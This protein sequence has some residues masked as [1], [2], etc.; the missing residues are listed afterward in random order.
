MANQFGRP[1]RRADLA[2][3]FHETLV[4][5]GVT[6]LEGA[7]RATI[8]KRIAEV[9]VLMRVSEASALKNFRDADAVALAESTADQWHAAEAAEDAAGGLS[10]DIPAEDAAQLVMGLAM[11]VG[12]LV[13][14][15]YGEL[16]A[17]VGQPLD[18]LC[19][20]G[21]NL[22]DSLE[23]SAAR[24][25]TSLQVL[26]TTHRAIKSAADGVADGSVPVVIPESGRTVFATRLYEDAKLAR[27]LQP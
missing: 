24:V 1:G 16:P 27:D 26:T 25:E 2:R 7:A 18:A 22:R 23:P 6:P 17:A 20:L 3:L 9:A 14:E 19:E 10:V 21:A 8:D 11:A 12:Q 15:V 5:R 13:R 4:A